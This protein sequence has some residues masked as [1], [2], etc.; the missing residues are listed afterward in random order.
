ML[1]IPA[2]EFTMGSP[3]SEEGRFENE[4]PQHRVTISYPLAVGKYEI[5]V[6]E[7]A[8]FIAD[9]GYVAKTR[10]RYSTGSKW[11]SGPHYS[12]ED[13]GFH[14][15]SCEPAVCITWSDA[16][17]YADWLCKGYRLMSEAEWEY[18]ARGG[19]PSPRPWGPGLSHDDANFGEDE[20]CQPS[21]QGRD[22][23]K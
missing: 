12:W 15:A 5:T 16:K 2:G 17:A 14:Q 11:A 9:T 23:G 20:C 3:S 6:A 19:T 13:P 4:G 21:V 18:A 8:Q 7:F 10:C 1:V 22:Q